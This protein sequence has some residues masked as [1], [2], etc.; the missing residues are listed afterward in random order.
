MHNIAMA[1]GMYSPLVVQK[2][3]TYLTVLSKYEGEY[4]LSKA[5]VHT[6]MF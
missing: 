4:L 5:T 2:I 3:G 1:M 6:S